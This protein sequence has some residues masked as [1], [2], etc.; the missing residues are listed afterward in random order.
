[1]L[2]NALAGPTLGVA[3]FQWALRSTPSGIVLPIVATTP[4]AVIP[5][6]YYLENDRPGI[7]SLAG[8]ALAVAGVAGLTL[9]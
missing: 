2:L 9:V 6:T 4:L 5:F 7:R 8:G 3:C 1:V